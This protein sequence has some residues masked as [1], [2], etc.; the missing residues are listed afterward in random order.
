MAVLLRQDEAGDKKSNIELEKFSGWLSD[1]LTI[2]DPF[3]QFQLVTQVTLKIKEVTGSVDLDFGERWDVQHNS[4]VYP[5]CEAPKIAKLVQIT[6]ITMVYGTQITIVTG[7]NLNQLI[8]GGPHIAGY[9]YVYL[10]VSENWP[11]TDQS[12]T[13]E[14]DSWWPVWDALQEIV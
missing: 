1:L 13:V 6:P 14:S 3:G 8:T 9:L 7:A 12:S 5:Q 2:N 10:W 4:K 11:V